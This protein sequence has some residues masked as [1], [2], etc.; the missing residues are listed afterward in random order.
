MAEPWVGDRRGRVA[1]PGEGSAVPGKLNTALLFKKKK[2]DRLKVARFWEA[3]G[4]DF[5][6][7]PDRSWGDVHLL[8]FPILQLNHFYLLC[9]DFKTERLEII[10]SSAS[11]E[12]T[13][14]KY[15][16]TPENVKLL[17][18]EYFA[19]VGEKFKSIICENL[20]CKRM[21]MKWRD[22]GNEVDCG[23]YLMWHMES[24]VGER[25]TKWDCGLTRGDR[26]Q[27]QML[28][29]RYISLFRWKVD[30]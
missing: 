13:R 10:D 7:G 24:Y 18:T 14:V 8:F 6:L 2:I 20:K 28:R 26:L 5:A 29:L 16:D 27:F 1:D 30:S 9:V 19:S 22:T 11:T 25:V 3:L 17:L 12:A 23:V 4:A 21:P 15:G